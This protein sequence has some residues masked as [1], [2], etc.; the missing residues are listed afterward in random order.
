MCFTRKEKRKKSLD[1]RPFLGGARTESTGFSFFFFPSFFLL[2][3][4]P[5]RVLAGNILF[6]FSFL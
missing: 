5:S 4:V 6:S 1:E 2:V 3:V